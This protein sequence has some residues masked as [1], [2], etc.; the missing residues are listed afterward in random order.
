MQLSGTMGVEKGIR[1]AF[2]TSFSLV[3]W[4]LALAIAWVHNGKLLYFKAFLPIYIPLWRHQKYWKW[5]SGAKPS[6]SFWRC[7]SVLFFLLSLF[8]CV[9]LSFLLS[10]EAKPQ[11]KLKPLTK[12]RQQTGFTFKETV[13]CDVTQSSGVTYIQSVLNMTIH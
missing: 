6:L 11:T 1:N 9:L 3:W 10:S 13:L 7:V 8:Y 4:A 12:T 5:F 2:S